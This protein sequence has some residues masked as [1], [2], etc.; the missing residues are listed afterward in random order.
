VRTLQKTLQ[1]AMAVAGPAGSDLGRRGRATLGGIVRSQ[2]D[3]PAKRDRYY[4]VLADLGEV[5][6]VGCHRWVDP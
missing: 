6:E 2:M 4:L 3:F 5:W 1:K